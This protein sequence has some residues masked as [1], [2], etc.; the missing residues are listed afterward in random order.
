M[1][2]DDT[3]LLASIIKE[4]ALSSY[5][6]YKCKVI[7]CLLHA[8]AIYN[9]RMFGESLLSGE[10][11]LCDHF[12]GRPK[13]ELYWIVEMNTGGECLPTSSKIMNLQVFVCLF[14]FLNTMIA[15]L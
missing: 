12:G 4:R 10:K 9:L 15:I 3:E 7:S 11:G 2:S 14:V 5:L 1:K 13:N 8:T 6:I